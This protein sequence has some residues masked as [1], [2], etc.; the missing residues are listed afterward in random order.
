MVPLPR[1]YPFHTFCVVIYFNSNYI[2]NHIKHYAFMDFGFQQFY[3]YMPQYDFFVLFLLW[4]SRVSWMYSLM[5]FIH[6]Q[7][8]LLLCLLSSL[9]LELQSYLLVENEINEKS[10][11][12]IMSHMSL[13]LLSI[14]HPSVLC[15]SV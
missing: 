13:M 14:F 2:L 7:T 9:L 8:S 1:R 10:N 5:P 15:A 11:Y 4:T 3:Y 6:F 12:F